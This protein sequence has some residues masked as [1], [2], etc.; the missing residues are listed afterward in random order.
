MDQETQASL[1][2][3][4][5]R[6]AADLNELRQNG[7]MDEGAFLSFARDRG[8]SVAGVVTGEPGEYHRRGWLPGD[9]S[10]AGDKP[11]FHPFRFYALDRLV[12]CEET[13]AAL[14][15][16]CPGFQDDDDLCARSAT[17]NEVVDLAVLLEPIYWPLIADKMVFGGGS[18]P[19]EIKAR[20]DA[21]H[22]K[23]IGL[24]KALD[25]DHWKA[26]HA[27]LRRDTA[28]LDDNPDLYVLLRVS[29]W[30]QREKLKG[31][32]SGAL[33]MR[34]MAEVIRRGFEEAQ[35]VQWPEE[36]ESFAEWFPTGLKLTFGS[37]RPLDDVLGTK[38]YV[39]Y[40]F[41]LFTG[42]LVRWY[43]EGET[44][45]SAIFQ[46]LKDPAKLGI[47]T[48]NLQ[49]VLAKERD[50]IA[51]KLGHW[52]EEDK[53]LR[54]FSIISFDLDVSANS[55]TI[56]RQVTNASIVGYI[57]AHKPDFEIA[58]FTP[59]ELGEIAA[60]IDESHGF[61]GAPLRNAPWTGVKTGGEFEARYRKLTVSKRSAIKGK[62]WGSALAQYAVAR[63]HR[64]DNGELRPLIHEV[65]IALQT[66]IAHYDLEKEYF[67]FQPQTFKRVRRKPYPPYISGSE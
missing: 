13:M 62:E 15:R 11:L 36:Y 5:Q 4:R 9:G 31:L 17:W 32:I 23:V 56:E 14:K 21:Y 35:Q 10:N 45:Y 27:Q 33:W 1:Q 52:L 39:A 42:S 54:R 53:T 46:I 55:K 57:A 20:F 3:Y 59:A 8:V 12:R 43:V 65:Q 29:K 6:W 49:G 48:V 44:E 50:N 28:S 47:E 63:P 30:D 60:G 38:P 51:L 25:S 26:L 2:E 67:G 58:N 41:G 7:L 19:H 22:Q 61:S 18:P 24:L 16:H 64:T 66:R 40:N 34:H 37:E